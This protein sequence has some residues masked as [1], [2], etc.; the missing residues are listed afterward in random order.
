MNRSFVS[1]K[2]KMSSLKNNDKSKISSNMKDKDSLP[3]FPS[4]KKKEK[5]KEKEKKYP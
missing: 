3:S 2:N 5:E 1:D 4:K